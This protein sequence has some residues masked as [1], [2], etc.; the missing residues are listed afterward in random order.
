MET[1]TYHPV[2]ARITE[3]LT[4]AGADFHTFTHEAVRTSEEVAAV[5]PE[6]T[7][8]QGA[9]ALIVRIKKKGDPERQFVQLVIP[10]DSKF[11]A[12][13]AR[14]VLTAKDVRFATEAEVHTLTDGVQSGGVPPFGNLFNIPVY[15]DHSLLAHD[16]IIFNAG[17]RR[18]SI[19]LSTEDY[20]RI[21]EPTVTDL[22]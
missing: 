11:S 18:V 8:S 2:V 5:R 13:K 15:V 21:V 6:Y 20:L 4:G 16:E 17:D 14:A 1:E 7:L 12:S 9:K 19:A 3:L 10:G 22:V